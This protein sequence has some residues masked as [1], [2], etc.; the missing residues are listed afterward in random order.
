VCIVG[1]DLF[2]SAVL[3]LSYGRPNQI[4][5]SLSQHS[6]LGSVLFVNY[7]LVA[8]PILIV[9][10]TGTPIGP[11]GMKISVWLGELTIFSWA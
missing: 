9:P 4:A 1:S 2:I 6:R 10:T 5:W 11:T 3:S 7:R 8:C